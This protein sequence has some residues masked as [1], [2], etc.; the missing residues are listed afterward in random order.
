MTSELRTQLLFLLALTIV[1]TVVAVVRELT[2]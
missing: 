2:P 1:F